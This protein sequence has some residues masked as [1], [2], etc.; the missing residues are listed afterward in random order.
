MFN[1]EVE[2]FAREIIKPSSPQIH[3]MKPFKLNFF[4]QLT[5]SIYGTGILFYS[6]SE[7]SF[8]P[9]IIL[10]Q[11]KTSLSET[12]NLFYPLSG[13][14]KDNMFVDSFDE[15]V[16]FLSA[17]AGCRLSEFLKLHEV[18]SLNK[19]LPCHPF[20]KEFKSEVAPLVCQ[21]T[22]FAC[23]GIAIGLAVSHKLVDG[24]TYIN[25]NNL[26]STISRGSQYHNVGFHGLAE[27]SKVF[28]PQNEVPKNYL[29]TMENLWFLEYNN[30]ITKRFTFDAKSL[31]ELRAIAKGE[32]EISPS[33]V[34]ALSGFIWKRFMAASWT[35]SAS[36]KPSIAVQA[37]NL[38]PRM[39]PPM[40]HNSIGNLFWWASCAA[41]IAD[42][43][44]TEL[45]E[46]VK[47][48]RESVEGFDEEYLNSLQGEQGFEAL[49]DFINQLETMFSYEKPDM[50]AFTSWFD[51]MLYELDFGWGKPQ[52][53][54]PF[55][56]VGSDFRNLV[57]FV[58]TKCGKDVEA[59]ITLDEKRM[60][61]LEKDAEFLKF[62]SPTPKISSL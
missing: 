31:N 53:V 35:I 62:T 15:G 49:G 44:S 36:S 18:K 30:Y 45:F 54:A 28:P 50:L 17:Q 48:M 5:P 6:I 46:L 38:R 58:R 37:V 47:L 21:A 1:F 22:I 20:S 4:D 39:N 10:P 23:G 57:V 3:G 56:E 34:Q 13:R 40:L 11:L 52:W 33:R 2:I 27:A 29:S 59:W 32:L 55:G 61:L 16:P 41:D 19:L 12:L 51:L 24:Q 42:E 25:F 9:T 8:T 14:I 26:W 43:T 7:T 60:L